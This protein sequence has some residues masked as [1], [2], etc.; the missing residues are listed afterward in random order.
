MLRLVSRSKDVPSV[1]SRV[2]AK[3]RHEFKS[4]QLAFQSAFLVSQRQALLPYL[5]A[6][7]G[8]NLEAFP[9]EASENELVRQLYDDV[10]DLY[11][12]EHRLMAQADLLEQM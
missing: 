10:N 9:D 4:E 12:D 11:T 8:G 5:Q 6:A 1:A 7:S 2:I 3:A